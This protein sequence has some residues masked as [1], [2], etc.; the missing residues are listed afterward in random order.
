[1]F[2]LPQSILKEVD[3]ICRAFLWGCNAEKKKIALV[4]WEKICLPKRKGGLNVKDSSNWNIASVGQLL[5]QIVVNKESLW[6]KWI[7]GNVYK[8]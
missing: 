1:V 3:K 5:W 2:I 4:S 6:L 8:N 7:H